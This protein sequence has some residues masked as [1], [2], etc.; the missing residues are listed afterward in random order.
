MKKGKLRQSIKVIGQG[1]E[2]KK[3]KQVMQRRAHEYL[4][5][6]Q[7]K[8]PY[9]FSEWD[10]CLNYKCNHLQHYDKFKVHHN[11][12]MDIYL[13]SKEQENNLLELMRTF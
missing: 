2:C 13:K 5:D 3:C 10:V 12:D 1:E 6:K 9:H 7:Q 4:T 8:A 11:N